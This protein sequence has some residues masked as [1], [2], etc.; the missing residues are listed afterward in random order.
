[1]ETREFLLNL[2][3]AAL[4]A[5][6]PLQV[7]PRHLPKPPRGR[8]V[9]VAA[10][11]A[12]AAMAQSVEKAWTGPLSGLA[13]TRYGHGVR[14]ER[15]EVVEAG[16]PYPDDVGQATSGRALE[17]MAK[18]S[19]DD[20]ALFLISGGGSSLL[21]RPA[22]G[23]SLADKQLVTRALLASG[24]TISEI[25]QVRKHL[26]AIKGGR[27]AEAAL[28]ARMATLVISDV[29][30]DDPATVASGPT[31]ADPTTLADARDVLAAHAIS[32][33]SSVTRHLA[34]PANETPKTL[35][36]TDVR[37]VARAAD[38]L[39]AAATHARDLGVKTTVLGDDLE[40]EARNLAADH[41]KLARDSAPS[42]LLS[43]GE[44][45]VTV[46]AAGGRGGRNTEYLLALALA[47]DGDQRIHAIACDTDGIDG[48]E[49]NAGAIVGPDT[50][51]R[52]R[53]LGLDARA[54]LDAHV[55]YDF[56]SALGDLVVTGP[57]RTN[58][59]DFR[60]ILIGSVASALIDL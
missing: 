28:P 3:H 18:L 53:A 29:P 51:V 57:T 20:L 38:A 41:A 31:L 16:H 26:S 4:A 2:F 12:A 15:I 44:T 55:A 33:P 21:A 10:G 22:S 47:L 35:P 54:M 56:F 43:G 48:T 60:A 24:A 9:V 45:T 36:A 8:T 13:V 5:V 30:G 52:A 25:N 27:L 50:L 14:C 42:L 19:A 6:E 32:A 37:I 39:N 17:L 7:V 40:G 34:D 46:G 59:N 23:L 1:M 58:V 11:K 49:E